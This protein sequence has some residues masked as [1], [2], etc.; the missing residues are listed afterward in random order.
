MWPERAKVQRVLLEESNAFIRSPR[1]GA[2][3]MILE[4]P[5]GSA[6]NWIKVKRVFEDKTRWAPVHVHL[7]FEERFEIKGGH[8]DA[9]IRGDDVRLAPGDTFFVGKGQP[10]VN[11]TNRATS[12]SS[13]LEY[14]QT[15]TPATEGARSYV[16]T[17]AQVLR[18]GRDRDGELPW[19]LVLAIG[20]VTHERTYVNVRPY[21]LQEKVLL[22]LGN[23]IAGA[24]RFTVNLG[25]QPPRRPAPRGVRSP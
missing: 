14:I 17:L 19:P 18:D 24:Q 1:T 23:R 5:G 12:A 20:D 9:K 2:K 6:G 11:P 22:P 7:D 10:H 8:A 3:M 13:P 15:F 4:V 21:S 16:R 25:R